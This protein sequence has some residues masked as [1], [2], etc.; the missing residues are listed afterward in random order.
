MTITTKFQKVNKKGKNVPLQLLFIDGAAISTDNNE[1]YA[2]WNLSLS[3]IEDLFEETD[4]QSDIIIPLNDDIMYGFIKNIF[5]P[6]CYKKHQK[7]K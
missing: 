5:S 6:K 7:N 3:G 1:F 4:I 2:S